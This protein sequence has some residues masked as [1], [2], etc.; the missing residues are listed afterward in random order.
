MRYRNRP[1]VAGLSLFLGI[2]LMTLGCN[3]EPSGP[4]G[5]GTDIPF[6]PEGVLDFVRPDSSIITRIVIELA[7]SP[8][9][10]AQ[11]LMYRRTLPDRGGML[12]VD[13]VETMRSFW[14]KN[15]AL[16]LDILFVDTDGHIVNIA[17]RTTPFSEEQIKSTGPARY[18][19]EVRAGFTDRYGITDADRI[20][21]RR[22]TFD[23]P[24]S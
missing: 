14:M 21:W 6:T 18:V 16:S 12:F 7:E 3:R 1:A 17:K 13:P 19:V 10:Q 8:E 11:G 22:E 2:A 5:L 15:T 20:V 4:E 23:S 24:S 9:E